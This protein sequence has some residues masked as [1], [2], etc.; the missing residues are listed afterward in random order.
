MVAQDWIL[1]SNGTRRKLLVLVLS[2]FSLTW[3]IKKFDIRVHHK[4]TQCKHSSGSKK[5]P[6]MQIPGDSDEINKILCC[7]HMLQVVLN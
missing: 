4:K 3:I 7:G 6:S 2:K 1:D 5:H